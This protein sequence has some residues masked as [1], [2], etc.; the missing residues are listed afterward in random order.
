MKS[1][2]LTRTFEEI[3]RAIFAQASRDVHMD[4]FLSHHNLFHS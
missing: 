4:L 3:R 1:L 2:S